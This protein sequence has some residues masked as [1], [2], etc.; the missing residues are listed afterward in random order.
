MK[1][2]MLIALAATV[3]GCGADSAGHLSGNLL[4]DSC[5][6]PLVVSLSPSELPATLSGDTAG[7]TDTLDLSTCAEAPGEAM[8]P[9]VVYEVS[10]VVGAT[11]RFTMTAEVDGPNLLAVGAG[12]GDSTD[13]CPNA[14]LTDAGSVH[15]DVWLA[16]EE[17]VS[18]FVDGAGAGVRAGPY[19]ISIT[20][21]CGADERCD[22]DGR[23]TAPPDED[24]PPTTVAAVT[25]DSCATPHVINTASLEATDAGPL[26]LRGDLSA[27]VGDTHHALACPDVVNVGVHVSDEVWA[28]SPPRD[29]TWRATVTPDSDGVD[30]ML[31]LLRG[32]T[33]ADATCSAYVDTEPAGI[34]DSLTFQAGPGDTV[35][36]VVDA[37]RPEAAG[38]YSLTL[39]ETCATGCRS[40][41]GDED[42][43]GGTCECG[44]ASTCVL[45]ACVPA[46]DVVGDSCQ[47][48]IALGP[49]LPSTARGSLTAPTWRDSHEIRDC[50]AYVT[51][52]ASADM[53]FTFT[54]PTADDYV[55]T[56]HSQ[57][58]G[59]DTMIVAYT[60]ARCT[61]DC[62][63]FTDR[64][65]AM[66]SSASERL[67]LSVTDAPQTFWIVVDAWVPGAAGDFSVTVDRALSTACHGVCDQDACSCSQGDT[68]L[69]GTCVAS[70]LVSGN[71]CDNPESLTLARPEV[72][73]LAGDGFSPDYDA[74]GCPGAQPTA[75]AGAAG[76]DNVWRFDAPGAGDYTIR[77]R[78]TDGAADLV[79]YA[80]DDT[81]C[82]AD[83]CVA[84]TDWH[85]SSVGEETLLVSAV[86]AGPILIVV[87]SFDGGGGAYEIIALA[88]CE[89]RCGSAACGTDDGC[90]GACGCESGALCRDAVCLASTDV[91]GDRCDAPTA[92]DTTQMPVRQRGD[93]SAPHALSDQH[94]ATGCSP[95]GASGRG[96][97]DEVWTFRA[98]DAGAYRVTATPDAGGRLSD[99]VL[100]LLDGDACAGSCRAHADNHGIE[101]PE[102]LVFDAEKDEDVVIVVDAW[103]PSLTDAY[104]LE[105][106]PL[107]APSCTAGSCGDDGCGGLCGCGAGQACGL[108][109][110]CVASSAGDT[111]D[112][113]LTLDADGFGQSSIN[114]TDHVSAAACVGV[115]QSG[116]PDQIWGLMLPNT[117]ALE[118]EVR[119]DTGDVALF[120]MAGCEAACLAYTDAGGAGH[121]ETLVL[122]GLPG[123]T[124]FVAV[125]GAST[126]TYTIS[127][128]PVCEAQ[129]AGCGSDDGCGETCGC[130]D[131][132]VCATNGSCEPADSVSGNTCA[133][134]S[135]LTNEAGVFRGSGDLMDP[136]MVSDTLSASA[137]GNIWLAGAGSAEQVWT[138]EAPDD[139]DFDVT[140]RMTGTAD[141]MLY[142]FDD[143]SCSRCVGHVDAALSGAEERLRLPGLSAGDRLSLVV[144]AYA[145]HAGGA[146]EIEVARACTSNCNGC[147]L[148]DGCGGICDCADGDLCD[149][150]HCTEPASAGGNQCATATP[151]AL[152]ASTLGSDLSDPQ[153]RDDRHSATGCAGAGTFTGAG[154]RDEVW[155]F[156]TERAGAHTVRLTPHGEADLM[157]YAFSD[158]GCLE[159]ACLAV[160]DGAGRGGAETL[161]IDAAVGSTIYLVV[162]A[163]AQSAGGAYD[164]VVEAP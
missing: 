114:A 137:C 108:G 14:S 123:S 16:P 51:G 38:A 136:A 74:H 49:L 71:H 81:A 103:L 101:G 76:R 89:P 159:Q 148:S 67:V 21:G 145:P 22:D 65:H 116:A 105:I 80:F 128:E 61:E 82:A 152:D 4:G 17:P 156:E 75:H 119:P 70:G 46:S 94:A 69:D 104:T 135:A 139:G 26:T 151:L 52:G 42:G 157:V 107:C 120:A 28:F 92:L 161:L 140:L 91:T 87:D 50:G 34:Q 117:G 163:W 72:G 153:L 127:A 24:P 31:Y 73:D 20:C 1:R 32:D 37:W 133:A 11:Y 44:P 68:C 5:K 18:L 40:S 58:A 110:S 90:G 15:I 2:F 53:A 129:C 62:A 160:T 154:N 138:F 60:D 143:A 109:G 36:L 113:P 102:T 98:P 99:L 85:A 111:C 63:G 9:D 121:P 93:L 106:V 112:L 55:V 78:P 30:T 3:A 146:Y 125:E 33:C 144:D 86:S 25:G 41:C 10:S 79:L 147:G 57:S 100:Y 6:D 162:D 130:A 88:V 158:A 7:F 122:R 95:Q 142:A 96:A 141:L 134:P 59:A 23:C 118:I 115:A 155:R 83:S 48:P 150:G 12:C 164:I 84:H 124:L 126:T 39:Q 54:A 29:G 97:P 149:A 77:A 66:A 132:G 45:G 64:Q 35:R 56:V 27:A 43:C 19:T 131:G 47:S 8:S 13:E